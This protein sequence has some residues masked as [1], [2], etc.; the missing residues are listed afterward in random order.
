MPVELAETLGKEN[1][2]SGRIY[3]TVLE[4][5]RDNRQLILDKFPN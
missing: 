5:C 4:R 2:T 3:R 1:T